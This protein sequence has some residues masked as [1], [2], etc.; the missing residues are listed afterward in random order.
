MMDLSNLQIA[1]TSPKRISFI[2]DWIQHAPFAFVL[3]QWH[4]PDLFV[5]LGTRTG[6]SYCSFCQAIEYLSLPTKCYAVDTWKGDEHA[7]RYS[8]EVFEEFKEY[9]DMN[10]NAFSS[11]MRMTFDEG[12]DYFSDGTVDLLHIDGCHYYEN[13]K[14][15]FESWLEKMSSRGIVLFHDTNLKHEDYGVWRLFEELGT[16]YPVFEFLHG[17]GLGV[18]AVGPE[19]QDTKL[20]NL[21]EITPEETVEIR[22]FFSSLG[23]LVDV[24]DQLTK[25]N[26]RLVETQGQLAETQG[27][28]GETQQRLGAH[29]SSL[30]ADLSQRHADIDIMLNSW[31]WRITG[32]LRRLYESLRPRSR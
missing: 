14:H 26:E 19:I 29:I 1:Y 7:G 8:E 23:R 21:F 6:V 24:E 18:V 4:K 28:L 9:H 16:K 15:D 31:S 20:R 5:E 11:L 13:V 3:T 25:T 2:T 22:N 17:S 27:R 10:Y 30:E 32:P 12:L